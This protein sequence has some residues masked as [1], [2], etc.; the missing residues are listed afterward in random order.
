MS[1]ALILGA[2]SA[3]TLCGTRCDPYISFAAL[4]VFLFG[5][6]NAFWGRLLQ[7]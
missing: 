4:L 3:L 1:D 2:A 5:L 6:A 7:R